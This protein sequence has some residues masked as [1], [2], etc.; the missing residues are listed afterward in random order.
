MC[1]SPPCH[2]QA[3]PGSLAA[4]GRSRSPHR[5]LRSFSGRAKSS[6]DGDQYF[7]SFFSADLP[8]TEQEPE[9]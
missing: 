8:A 6:L 4:L 3:I 7:H 2:V 5:C 1:S 9:A